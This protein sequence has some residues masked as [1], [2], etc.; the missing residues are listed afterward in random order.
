MSP[1]SNPLHSKHRAKQ[2]ILMGF[3]MPACTFEEPCS[4]YKCHNPLPHPPLRG[5]RVGVCEGSTILHK[6]KTPSPSVRSPGSILQKQQIFVHRGNM[7]YDT[8]NITSVTRKPLIYS[9]R[10]FR[11]CPYPH[12]LVSTLLPTYNVINILL[13][14]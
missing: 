3:K 13:I 7:V 9:L 5:L 14:S 10:Y 6:A 8:S 4:L 1:C 11:I 12:P 2:L